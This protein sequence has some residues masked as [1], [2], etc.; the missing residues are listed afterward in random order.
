MG[1]NDNDLTHL[2]GHWAQQRQDWPL[3][4]EPSLDW[5]SVFVMTQGTLSVHMWPPVH[6][7]VYDHSLHIK[8][9]KGDD[10]GGS[11]DI[12]EEEKPEVI[13]CLC[14]LGEQ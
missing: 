4:S 12:V 14:I 2:L 8:A 5:G 7:G 13:R 11:L 6:C 9:S 1:P 10:K 3:Q